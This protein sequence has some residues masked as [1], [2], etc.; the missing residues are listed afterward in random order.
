M[1]INSI[2]GHHMVL[3]LWPPSH[4]KLKK[5]YFVNGNEGNCFIASQDHRF[6]EMRVK[7]HLYSV[8]CLINVTL[9]F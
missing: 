4:T 9:A 6:L 1:N 8:F 7:Q 3:L 5:L 2:P